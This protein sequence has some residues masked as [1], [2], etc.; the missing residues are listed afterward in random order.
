MMEQTKKD[1]KEKNCVNCARTNCK[2]HGCSFPGV[3]KMY[4]EK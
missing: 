4:K 1:G 2:N 3:C